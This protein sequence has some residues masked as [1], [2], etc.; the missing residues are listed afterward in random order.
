MLSQ[1]TIII[2]EAQPGIGINHGSL[3]FHSVDTRVNLQSLN[4]AQ[5]LGPGRNATRKPNLK[6][7]FTDVGLHQHESGLKE[8]RSE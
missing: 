3:P 2:Q 4:R 1:G 6:K 7:T 5:E 8:A